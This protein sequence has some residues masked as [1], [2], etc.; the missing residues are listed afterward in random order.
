[1]NAKQLVLIQK[2]IRSITANKQVLTTMLVVPLVLTIVIPSVFVLC[3]VLEPESISDFQILLDML[4]NA[5]VG[6]EQQLLLSLVL[7]QIMPVFFLM[8]PIMA[9]SVMAAGSFVGEKEKHTLETL[10]YSPLSLKEIFQA[11]ILA[12]FFVGMAVSLLSFALMLLVVEVE[13]ILFLGGGI[14]PDASWL[15]ILLLISPAISLAGIAITVRGSAKAQTMEEAQQKV[16][17]LVF[18][19]LALIM[20]Q[21]GG[22]LLINAWLLLALGFVLVI[23]DILLLR[24]VAGR[25]TYEQLLK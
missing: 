12:G 21:F 24:S 8:I 15:V 7:N 16:V 14:L 6:N 5:T 3:T 23:A 11:K 20:G 19:I 17:F 10:L 22:I 1:M 4:P 9:S 2:D 25:F 13:M 18:P